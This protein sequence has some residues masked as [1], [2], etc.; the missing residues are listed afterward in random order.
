MTTQ[1]SLSRLS[2][3]EYAAVI[4]AAKAR[5]LE[6]RREAI[7]EFWSAVA[8]AVRRAVQRGT[9]RHP[10]RPRFDAGSTLRGAR[11]SH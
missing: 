4:D 10:R 11:G 2:P 3:L 1:H 8:R 6:L 5:A 9:A 7:R